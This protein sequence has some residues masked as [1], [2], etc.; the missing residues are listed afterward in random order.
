MSSFLAA[1]RPIYHSS[2]F[3]ERRKTEVA[4]RARRELKR[5]RKRNDKTLLCNRCYILLICQVKLPKMIT[6]TL[7]KYLC[8]PIAFGRLFFSHSTIAYFKMR[9]GYPAK[10]SLIVCVC[11]E[12]NSL[13]R[14]DKTDSRKKKSFVVA[15]GE[16][17]REYLICE[18][19]RKRSE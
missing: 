13:L 15:V 5:R 14:K 16:I 17:K 9:W 18:R 1:I 19:K 6:P 3:S 2:H 11:M 10:G 4:N 7:L 12:Y 8:G